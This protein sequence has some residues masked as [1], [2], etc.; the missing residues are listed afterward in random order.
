MTTNGMQESRSSGRS[1]K[2]M[3]KV[4][5]VQWNANSLTST[6]DITTVDKGGHCLW[7][8]SNYT[9]K[10][11]NHDNRNWFW[12][13]RFWWVAFIFL[14]FY[15]RRLTRKR[16]QSRMSE[17][18]IIQ[19]HR[20]CWSGWKISVSR[21]DNPWSRV[22][23]DAWQSQYHWFQVIWA[24]EKTTEAWHQLHAMFTLSGK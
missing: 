8:K 19:I 13:R 24:C 7:F 1:S 11:V 6:N 18:E 16:N 20:K 3:I 17:E 2:L 23:H 14:S 5:W 21:K 15:R 10:E 12:R 4:L 9:N 22:W